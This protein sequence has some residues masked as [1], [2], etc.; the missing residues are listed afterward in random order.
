MIPRARWVGP[1][2]VGFLAVLGL[3]LSPTVHDTSALYAGTT[4][5]GVNALAGGSFS[6]G[7]APPVTRTARGVN[8][9]LSWPAVTFSSGTAPAYLVTRIQQDG[10][11]TAV[12]TG[13]DSPVFSGSLM[14]CVDRKPGAAALYTEQPVLVVGGQ[15]TWSLPPSTPA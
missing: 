5:P 3:S 13:A 8:T 11:R 9:Q 15:V 6:P 2:T 4:T 10:T 12:C 14:T 7:V 1:A